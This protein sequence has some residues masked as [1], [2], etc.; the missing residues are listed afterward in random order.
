MV[1]DSVGWEGV[2]IACRFWK[3]PRGVFKAAIHRIHLH[4]LVK[5]RALFP[6]IFCRF[7]HHRGYDWERNYLLWTKSGT[8]ESSAL[9]REEN[10]PLPNQ[11]KESSSER[12]KLVPSFTGLSYLYLKNLV[13]CY[14][15]RLKQNHASVS[16]YFI[17]QINLWEDIHWLQLASVILIRK[18]IAEQQ[19][20]WHPY[21]I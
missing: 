14:N 19:G 12:V 4:P 7:C 10:S 17:P 8:S 13:V 1:S 9:F 11:C 21:S 15:F 16:S 5:D 3:L 2:L 18:Q 20:I 6:P